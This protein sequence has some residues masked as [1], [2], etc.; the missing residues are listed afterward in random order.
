MKHLRLALVILTIIIGITDI[1]HAQSPRRPVRKYR[2]YVTPSNPIDT[3]WANDHSRWDFSG[4][5]GLYNPGFGADARVA[6]R[7]LNSVLEDVDDSL[8]A[9]VG[10]GFVGQTNTYGG[11]SVSTSLVEIPLLARWDFR[12]NNTNFIVG[13][14]VGFGILAGNSVTV[15]NVSYSTGGFYFLIGG[16]GIYKF[17]EHWGARANVDFGGYTNFSIGATYFL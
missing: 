14:N 12:I 3:R 4:L 7:V 5:L 9:E 1:T 16:Q 10:I 13:P 15:N 11:Q 17:N 2:P 6:Y 8:S